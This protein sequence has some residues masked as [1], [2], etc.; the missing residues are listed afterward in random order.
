VQG[1]GIVLF[2]SYTE[3]DRQAA[4]E[5]AAWLGQQGLEVYDWQDPR[6]RG[7]RFIEQI[8]VAI[9]T[10]D[11]FLAL[12]S[13]S[14]VASPWCRREREL[15]MQREQ[16]LQADG[17]AS[18]FVYVLKLLD[19]P[20]PDAGFLRNYDWLDL[21]NPQDRAARVGDLAR[22]LKPSSAAESADEPRPERGSP[23]FRN[24][25]D[26]LNRVLDGLTS[27]SGQHF[28]LV[29]A[30]PQLGKTW[31]L[32]RVSAEVALCG[33]P[34]W[35]ATVVDLREQSADVRGDAAMLL[36]KLFGRSQLVSTEH[37]ALLGIAKEIFERGRP[38]LCL[39]D[40]AELLD[41]ATAATLR[42][43]LSEI[44]HLVQDAGQI[45]VR[46]AV[47]V[48]S[49]REVEWRGV[50]PDPRLSP[51]PL[52]EFKPDVVQ[53]ALRD[54]AGQMGRNF[55]AQDFRNYALLVH[56]LT[57]GLPALLV[58]CLQW[59]RTEQ[60]LGMERLEDHEVFE[61]LADPYVQKE[62]L[63][64]ESLVPSGEGPAGEQ[65][66]ALEHAFRILAP[67]RLFT[68]SHLRHHLDLDPALSGALDDPGWS[69]EDLSRA[70]SGTALLKRP[71]NEPW[72]EI[73]AAIRRL[74]Y[75]YYYK[76]DQDRAAAHRDARRFVAVWARRQSGKERIIGLVECLWHEATALRLGRPA[77][78]ESALTASARSLSLALR[79]S[80]AYTLAE[81]RDY[82]AER[83][84]ND[85]EFQETVGDAVL[86]ARLVNIVVTP[87]EL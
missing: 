43:C 27:A 39:L 12:L 73:H 20:Y 67:Y 69:I 61:E 83:L 75:R 16:D 28:W 35:T 58:R 19:T 65:L 44:Y 6:Q 64:Q 9:N 79:P 82:A 63:T 30:P 33:P 49:R 15:A 87:Q 62:L 29:I 60:W 86:F 42:S 77:D 7:G 74:L 1:A 36:A 10:A 34:R 71:L 47:I 57:E 21:T 23:L 80:P 85:E 78:M 53:H 25:R 56:R 18:D 41:E 55:R 2:L 51:L 45:E 13:P 24:R 3:E 84:R 50:T 22:R 37:R 52:T 40:S 76:S 70:I 14:F 32:D 59:I 72:Q 31:F 26:E 66:F 5:I 17:S 54:L 81:L 8:E 11:C 68:Q 46:L 4:R 38:H 48:A